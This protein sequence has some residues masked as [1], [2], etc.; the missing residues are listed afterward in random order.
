MLPHHHLTAPYRHLKPTHRHIKLPC[1]PLI[2]PA[3]FLHT[4][5]PFNDLSSPFSASPLPFS[6]PQSPFIASPCPI[7]TVFPLL[8]VPLVP[9]HHHIPPVMVLY[10][11]SVAFW[12]SKTTH[13]QSNPS[14]LL[15]NG[16]NVF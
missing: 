16:S 13:L 1:R 9:L 8:L 15:S 10:R 6:V 7:N 14:P 3:T 4:L 5:S 2:H 11:L 12:P